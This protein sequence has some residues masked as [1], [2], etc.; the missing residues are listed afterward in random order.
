V[1]EIIALTVDGVTVEVPAGSSILDACD[2][3][4]AYVPRICAYPGLHPLGDCGLC[5]VGVGGDVRRACSV[6]AAAG[7]V[8]DTLHDEARGFRASSMKAVLGDHPHVCLTCPRRDGC[9]RDEC[10][11]GN[12]PEDRCC[13][14]FGRCELAR[15]A[16]FVGALETAPPYAHRHLGETVDHNIRRDL[17]LCVG[18]GRCVVACDTLEEAG[19]ALVLVET[20]T[21]LGAALAAGTKGL[22][23]GE[24]EA[25]KPRSYL[26]RHV[27]VPK[28][29]D[30]RSSGCTF[31]AACIMV[32]PTGALTAV[33]K[34]GSI[35][36][37]TRRER[38]TLRARVLPPEDRL[39]LKAEVIEE[40]VPA[41]EGV[42]R[43]FAADGRVLHISGVIDLRSALLAG[44][45]GSFAGEACAFQFEEDPLYTQRES[46]MLARHLQEHGHLPEGND[47]L[48]DVFG[49]D[50]DDGW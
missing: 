36:L 40:E 38:S 39:T 8:I 9:S 3:A 34:N 11:Y 18:C 27:A 16:A 23:P 13:G 10:V 29:D 43:L 14:E 22:Q 45:G 15:V 47:V 48:G 26:G 12:P 6:V 50:D 41:T 46:E 24:E 30:L 2:R 25:W 44:L 5:F 21:L 17:D 49:D 20:H 19:S 4:G 32:C 7:M 42:F 1:P 31:C 33:G 37:A 28:A 35:W